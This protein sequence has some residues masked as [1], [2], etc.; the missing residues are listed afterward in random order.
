MNWFALIITTVAGFSTMLGSLFILLPIKQKYISIFLGFA[1]GVMFGISIFDLIP[2]SFTYLATF[3]NSPILC[4]F[5]LF[6]SAILGTFLSDLFDAMVDKSNNNERLYKV[7]L[8]SLIAIIFHNIPE[9]IITY[10]STANDIQLGLTLA[11]AIAMHNIPEG[12]TIAIPIFQSTKKRSK[13]FFYTLIASLSEPIGAILAYIFLAR[14][15]NGWIM[16]FLLALTAGIMMY[17]ALKELLLTGIS[18]SKKQ[19][20]VFF[21]IGLLFIL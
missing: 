21:I 4:L 7:G 1:S 18:Y 10:L 17:I 9:G 3:Y 11:F 6:L 20:I 5:C 15:V 13:A 19:T 12:I 8:I 2:N 14:Y 16:G